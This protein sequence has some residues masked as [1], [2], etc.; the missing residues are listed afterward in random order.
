[1]EDKLY[2]SEYHQQII[3]KFVKNN[4]FAK[5]KT[6]NVLDLVRP[7][8]RDIILEVGCSSGA[9]SFICANSGAFVLGVDTNNTAIAVAKEFSGSMLR[10]EGHCEFN[11]GFAEN[12]L[13]SYHYNKV[14]MIDL[15]EHIDNET[16]EKML[17]SISNMLP[18]VHLFIYTPNK[19]HIFEIL[20]E[21]NI[22]LRRDPTHIGLRTMPETLK[23]LEKQGYKIV[24]FYNRPSHV[25]L[26]SN[27]EL[28][29]SRLP[30]IGKYFRRRLCIEA[31][32]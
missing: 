11:L 9:S 8:E 5:D 23:I 26:F 15:V 19:G 28:V 32:A 31:I 29:L 16:L 25:V 12:Y 4:R 3:K 2:S 24:R 7:G 17:N 13:T 20:K 22:I 10:G 14:I 27:A 18:G 21:R 1:M 30:L 6:R